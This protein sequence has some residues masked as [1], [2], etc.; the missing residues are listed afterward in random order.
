[1][2][3]NAYTFRKHVAECA[4]VAKLPV[5]QAEAMVLQRLADLRLQI[6]ENEERLDLRSIAAMRSR[7]VALLLAFDNSKGSSEEITFLM[8]HVARD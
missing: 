4:K 8:G 3:I 6:V 1:M 5:D 2:S 7:T